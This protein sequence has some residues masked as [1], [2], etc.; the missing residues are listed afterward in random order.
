MQKFLQKLDKAIFALLVAWCFFAFFLK[1]P[2]LTN[3]F[4]PLLFVGLIL[5][6]CFDFKTAKETF[7]TN[8][9]SNF[10][11]LLVFALLF[12]WA[13]II[14][15][16]SYTDM[17]PKEF[18]Q[19]IR[20]AL[21][22]IFLLTLLSWFGKKNLDNQK[23]I[24]FCFYAIVISF[25][26]N[27][28]YFFIQDIIAPESMYRRR[29]YNSP[30]IIDRGFSKI[31]ELYFSFVFIAFLVEKEKYKK[32]L[33]AIS[34]AIG[35]IYLILSGSRGGIVAFV[36]TFL[37]IL[38]CFIL[39][40]GIN[41]KMLFYAFSFIAITI[42]SLS[43][44]VNQ[45]EYLQKRYQ[46]THSSGRNFIIKERFPL[47]LE[48]KHALTG[49]GTGETQYQKFLN[50]QPSQIQ[51][52]LGPKCQNITNKN[53]YETNFCHDEPALL[54]IYWHYGILGSLGFLFIVCYLIFGSTKA[55]FKENNCYLFGLGCSVFSYFFITGLVENHTNL[56]ILV[57]CYTLYIIFKSAKFAKSSV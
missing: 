7:L 3:L 56:K 8:L 57:N 5:Y 38:A 45:N 13:I 30:S 14:S 32:I 44:T 51:K 19:L 15:L 26:I 10:I 41:K 35:I 11:P 40:N 48:S 23:L 9:K 34:L 37:F 54:G 25:S 16:N 2:P 36:A 31:F 46:T 43:I 24:K 47:L 52:K 39:K 42:L 53:L 55:F 22:F 17:N 21:F 33:I 4:A 27:L 20:H 12:I 1:V 29:Q 18:K 50:N 28:I 6:I 49:L